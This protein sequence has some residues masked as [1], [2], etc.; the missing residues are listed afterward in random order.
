MNDP[1]RPVASRTKWLLASASTVED[2]RGAFVGIAMRPPTTGVVD[3][4][5]MRLA[6]RSE[7]FAAE[8]V[9]LLARWEVLR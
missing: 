5:A 7:D 1:W 3:P 8:F 4:V 9:A 2:L 6:L